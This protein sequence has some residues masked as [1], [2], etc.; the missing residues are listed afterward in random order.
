MFRGTL[1]DANPEEKKEPFA[2]SE[3]IIFKEMKRQLDVSV[4]SK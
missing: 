2:R 4:V 1:Y 3:H